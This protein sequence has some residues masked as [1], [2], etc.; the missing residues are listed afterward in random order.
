MVC[1]VDFNM[2]V[3][4]NKLLEEKGIEYSVHSIGS[5]ASC[6]LE[7][8]QNGQTYPIESIIDTINEYLEAKWLE[9]KQSNDNIYLLNVVSKFEKES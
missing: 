9:V 6:G 8:K 3:E 5:C 2:I 7:L 4:I 1:V